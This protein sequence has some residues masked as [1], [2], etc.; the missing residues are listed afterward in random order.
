MVPLSDESGA[1]I[2]SQLG[3]GALRTLSLLP[4]FSGW[5]QSTRMHVRPRCGFHGNSEIGMQMVILLSRPD[6]PCCDTFE[7]KDSL[8]TPVPPSLPLPATRHTDGGTNPLTLRLTSRE[9]RVYIII[10]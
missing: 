4:A 2:Y 1:L 6:D 5:A 8:S 7:A 10:L 3:H 9:K